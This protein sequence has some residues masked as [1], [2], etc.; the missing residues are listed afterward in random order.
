[1]AQVPSPYTI[2][3][4]RHPEPIPLADIMG[5]VSNILAIPI[6]PFADWLSLL[7]S[8]LEEGQAETSSYLAPAIR[9]LE[10]FQALET[11][12]P[13]SGEI[14]VLMDID[15]SLRSCRALRDL[16][17]TSFGAEDVQKWLSYWRGVGALPPASI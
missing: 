17:A 7:A 10:S 6:V 16:S 12:N 4:L 2:L 11:L 1:M 14:A 9:L 5:Q 15:E 13:E 3:H 8:S